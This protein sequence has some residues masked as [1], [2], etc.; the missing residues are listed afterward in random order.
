[1]NYIGYWQCNKKD[2]TECGN[3]E[4]EEGDIIYIIAKKRASLY[5]SY[6]GESITVHRDS[7]EKAF[8]RIHKKGH[9]PSK[10]KKKSNNGYCELCD[11]WLKKRKCMTG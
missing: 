11:I 1:M 9:P 8:S 5:G 7:L 10:C 6:N 2:G 4:L 3:S